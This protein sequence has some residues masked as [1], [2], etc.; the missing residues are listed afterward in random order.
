MCRR[1]RGNS[2]LDDVESA[3]HHLHPFLKAIELMAGVI[4]LDTVELVAH[5]VEEGDKLVC[6]VP[7]DR[8]KRRRV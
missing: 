6:C 7:G 1:E 2:I 3:F 4:F 5:V 8:E